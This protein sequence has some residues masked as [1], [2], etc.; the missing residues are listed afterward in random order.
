[1]KS[2]YA[3]TKERRNDMLLKAK[4]V[5]QMVKEAEKQIN[6]GAIELLDKHINDLLYRIIISQKDKRITERNILLV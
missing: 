5:K 4:L 2:L 3:R 6:K 1:M